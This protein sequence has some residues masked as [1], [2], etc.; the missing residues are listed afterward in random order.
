MSLNCDSLYSWIV[1]DDA[2]DDEYDDYDDFNDDDVDEDFF[3]MENA[4]ILST[5]QLIQDIVEWHF[6]MLPKPLYDSANDCYTWK[7]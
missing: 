1:Y 7:T 4:S 2:N 6:W 3:R 5:L